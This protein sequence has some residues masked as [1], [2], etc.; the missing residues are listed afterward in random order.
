MKILHILFWCVYFSFFFY[1]ISS[2]PRSR[3]ADPEFLEL[4]TNALSH[5]VFLM[6]VAYINY[7]I[8]LPRYLIHK[9]GLQYT[10]EF[11]IVAC[12]VVFVYIH[13]KRWMVDGYSGQAAFY[14]ST[15]YPIISFVTSVLVS[16]FVAFLRFFTEWGELEEQR[17]QLKS[18][19]LSAE[20]KFLKNQINPHFLFNTLNNLYSLAY[21]HSPQ[22]T[23]IISRLSQMM[24]YMVYDSNHDL[25][26]LEKEIEYIKNYITLEKLRLNND[27]P[28]DFEVQGDPG[29]KK[30]VPLLLIPFMENA[31]KHGVSNNNPN[32]WVKAI[33]HCST[34]EIILEVSNSK[35]GKNGSA[36]SSTS[37]VG[38][39]NVKK[40]LDLR[41]DD[42]YSLQVSDLESRYTATLDLQLA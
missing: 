29:N 30:I 38:L 21:S 36:A 27:I 11:V 32:S 39:E 5:T 3:E 19:K 2:S 40:R 14:Y 24:R 4:F 37:G 28:I 8:I 12:L 10:V 17:E 6:I 42:K 22:T 7:F 13:A 15:R 9:N 35:T 1:Q 34:N 18:E 31:F 16:A 41:Y 26:P 23:E 25:V 33:L 20:L